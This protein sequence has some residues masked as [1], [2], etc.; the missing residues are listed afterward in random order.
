MYVPKNKGVKSTNISE[1]LKM[2][3]VHPGFVDLIKEPIYE[4]KFLN[5]IPMSVIMNYL[6]VET[7][8]KYGC[9][10]KELW[11]KNDNIWTYALCLSRGVKQ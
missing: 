4:S 9:V 11:T 1:D 3:R 6:C 2:I 10:T 8:R 5:F 7:P